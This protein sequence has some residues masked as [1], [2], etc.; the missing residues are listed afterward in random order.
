MLLGKNKYAYGYAGNDVFDVTP[1]VESKYA[2]NLGKV[3]VY[4]GDGD[5]IIYG[6]NRSQRPVVMNFYGGGGYDVAGFPDLL[7]DQRWQVSK[8]A[9]FISLKHSYYAITA[10]IYSDIEEIADNGGNRWSYSVLS[11][12]LDF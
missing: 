12:A 3:S 4:G 2:W 10:N 11:S 5:D 7:S 1:E 8:G 9:N 6:G